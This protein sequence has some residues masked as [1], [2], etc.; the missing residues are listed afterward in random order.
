L[1]DFEANVEGSRSAYASLH[2][3]LAQHN[4]TLT[5]TLDTRFNT[6]LG[7]LSTHISHQGDLGYIAGS[8]FVSYTV[9]TPAEVKA[10]SDE[11]INISEPLGQISGELAGK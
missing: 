2:P 8:P 7:L 3:V 9:L 10:L 1:V 5:S 11:V 4:P 6:L